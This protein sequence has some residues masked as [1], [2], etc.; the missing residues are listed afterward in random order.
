LVKICF[1]QFL[2]VP[3][4]YEKKKIIKEE[5]FTKDYD[6][7]ITG[8]RFSDLPGNLLPTDIIDINKEQAFY[9]ENNS[10][11]AYSNLTIY[12]EREETEDEFDKRKAETEV[13]LTESK[14]RRLE[15]YQKLKKEFES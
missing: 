1:I 7:V 3:L 5:I 13:Y 4:C 10:W 6:G 15:Q 9:S 2:F 12:R 11:D 14:Q 8:I